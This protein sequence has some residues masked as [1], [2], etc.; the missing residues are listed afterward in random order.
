MVFDL[1]IYS[2]TVSFV[3]GIELTL[4]HEYIFGL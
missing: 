4:T 1:V 3:L 2:M